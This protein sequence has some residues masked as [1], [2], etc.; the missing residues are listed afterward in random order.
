MTFF[1]TAVIFAM[2]LYWI[3]DYGV[4]IWWTLPRKQQEAALS[5]MGTI[6][7]PVLFQAAWIALVALEVYL[8]RDLSRLW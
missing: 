1:L 4:I 5:W 7:W 2:L 3:I 8:L 6:G